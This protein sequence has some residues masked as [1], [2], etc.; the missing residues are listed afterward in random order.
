VEAFVTAEI[1][2]GWDWVVWG[3]ADY[4]PTLPEL[5]TKRTEDCDGR[6]VLAA[7]LLRHRGI[8]A[9]LVADPR[10][11]WVRTPW[12]DTMNPLG[13]PVFKWTDEG[14]VIDW[15]RL[16]DPG[17]FA[18]GI[19]VFPLGRELVLLL[20]AWLLALHPGVGRLRPILGL[21][22]LG[23]ALAAWRLAG[24]DP[25][26]PSYTG[27]TLAAGLTLAGIVAVGKRTTARQIHA[28]GAVAVGEVVT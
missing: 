18:F 12:G 16:L 11:M 1:P 8:T 14:L 20:T 7:A 21:G 13:Q 5:L 23:A 6:A 28:D 26:A 27:I 24:A 22:L 15:K 9:D 10:H 19:A 4:T 17:P 3:A 2:Y 25:L